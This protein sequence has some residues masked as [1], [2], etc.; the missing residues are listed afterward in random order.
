MGSSLWKLILI[1]VALSTA[2]AWAKAPQL[3]KAA[4]GGRAKSGPPRVP[5]RVP[6]DEV[7]GGDHW[8]V[9]TDHG[10]VHVWRPGGYHAQSAGVVVYVHGYYTDVDGAWREHRLAHQFR[11]SGQ[12]ALFIVPEAPAANEEPVKWE[13][14]GELLQAVR[15]KTRERVPGGA[16]AVVGHS[17]A[18]RTLIKWLDSPRL[19]YLVLLDALYGS[20]EEIRAWVEG[21]R[22]RLVVIAQD[23][24]DKAEPFIRTLKYAAKR[25][26]IPDGYMD[27]TPRERRARV[28][29]LR[30]QYGHMELVTDGKVIPLLLR[31]SPLRH[32]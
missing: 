8:R 23:T 17:G 32:L 3:G 26:T 20:T 18:V 7:E 12:N 30:S 15:Q 5:P 10:P 1:V 6:R 28:L 25:V 2:Q 9:M 14:V 21:A 29:Y 16:L 13:N 24:L 4:R 27:F 19:S 22:G 11:E 31:L